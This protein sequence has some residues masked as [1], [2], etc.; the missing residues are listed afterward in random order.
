MDPR[1]KLISSN[2]VQCIR[3][4]KIQ[5]KHR[6]A[7]KHK[8]ITEDSELHTK[9]GISVDNFLKIEISSNIH[10]FGQTNKK[11]ISTALGNLQSIKDKSL[12]I[13]S[14]L[15]NDET[16]ICALTENWLHDHDHDK[17]WVKGLDL[18]MITSIKSLVVMFARS[19]E[20]SGLKGDK[21]EEVRSHRI[22][23]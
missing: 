2:T 12:D 8:V 21:H 9:Q 1:C 22:T 7:N 13:F 19:L 3:H 4:L 18:N 11:G 20:I 5:R 23:S 16:D 17:A 10:G 6:W 15:L 14:R